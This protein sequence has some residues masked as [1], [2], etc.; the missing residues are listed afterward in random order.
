MQPHPSA[1][2]TNDT[3]PGTEDWPHREC[4]Q[5]SHVDE[6]DDKPQ[7]QPKWPLRGQTHPTCHLTWVQTAQTRRDKSNNLTTPSTCKHPPR[8]VTRRSHSP[9]IQ[10]THLIPQRERERERRRRRRHK[11]DDNDNDNDNHND[12]NHNDRQRQRHNHNNNH[13]HNNHNH[14]H[15]GTS[16]PHPTPP[17]LIPPM[18]PKQPTPTPYERPTRRTPNANPTHSMNH[19]HPRHPIHGLYTASPTPSPPLP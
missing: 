7:Q 10:L 11:H 1:M 15:K 5:P 2:Q 3:T 17:S 12:D 6:S 9:P 13:N 8:R 18:S 4:G 16:P 19:P 14:N